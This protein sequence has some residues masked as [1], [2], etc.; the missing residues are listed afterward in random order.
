[1]RAGAWRGSTASFGRREDAARCTVA[2][3]LLSRKLDDAFWMEKAGTYALAL[4]ASKRPGADG[5]FQPRASSC[6]RASI[7]EERAR[8]VARTL[9]SPESFSGFGIRTL[10]KGQRPYNPPQLSQRDRLAPRQLAHRHGIFELRMQKLAAQVL[11]GEYDARAA[12]FGI[13]GCPSCTAGWGAARATWWSAT[14]VSCS[15]QAWA[16][17][18]FFLN[19][20]RLP[21]PLPGRAAQGAEDRQPASA[22]MLQ[23]LTLERLRIGD[24]LADPPVHA[25]RR[26]LLRRRPRDARRPAGDPDR[27][28][29]PDR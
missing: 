28:G 24:T 21:G 17:G 19:A 18:A 15:P 29:R 10:A 12:S 5:H 16:S 4:D 6:S 8:R 11:S 7:P 2:A 22:G 1:M 23:R 27:G 14:P 3:Q 13:T 20:A 25:Q 9:M 26:R